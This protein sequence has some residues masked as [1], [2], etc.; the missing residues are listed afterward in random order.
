MKRYFRLIVETFE[1]REVTGGQ[2]LT[3]KMMSLGGN[4]GNSSS[5]EGGS[6]EEGVQSIQGSVL[7]IIFVMLAVSSFICYI[8]DVVCSIRNN[9][10]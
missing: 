5:S 6:I 7:H 1:D 10:L 3:N 8:G 2:P 9:N 4:F